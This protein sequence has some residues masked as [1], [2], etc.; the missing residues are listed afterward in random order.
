M[1]KNDIKH[2]YVDSNNNVIDLFDVK[3]N[4][5]EKIISDKIKIH[6]IGKNSYVRLF[7][8][9]RMR[10]LRLVLGDDTSVEFGNNV[11]I[12]EE[13]KIML[14]KKKGSVIVGNNTFFGNCT[15]LCDEPNITFSIGNNCLIGF[16]VSMRV[17]D[18][19]TIY[20]MDSLYPINIPQDITIEDHVWIGREVVLLKGAK[21]PKDSVVG[22]RSVVTKALDKTNCIYAGTPAKLVKQNVNWNPSSVSDYLDKFKFNH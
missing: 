16:G 4:L 9:N 8:S 14:L 17:G 18:G 20:D 21:V 13:L 11:A 7:V 22:I 1:L 2:T 6:F 12:G 10:R 5:I 19:H 15:I 3:Y